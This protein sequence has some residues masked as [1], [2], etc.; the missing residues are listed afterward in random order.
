M[1]FGKRRNGLNCDRTG[2]D[3]SREFNVS[4][5][6]LRGSL[7][8]QFPVKKTVIKCEDAAVDEAD[9]VKWE[10]GGHIVENQEEMMHHMTPACR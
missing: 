9:K 6:L 7:R 10:K 1:I 4:L 5:M 8:K 3:S 2:A